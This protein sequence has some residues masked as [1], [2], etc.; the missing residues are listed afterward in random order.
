MSETTRQLIGLA[1]N[2]KDLDTQ[3]S[4]WSWMPIQLVHSLSIDANYENRFALTVEQVEAYS[5]ILEGIQ[6]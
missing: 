6:Q 4:P 3:F 1:K 5:W 2:L